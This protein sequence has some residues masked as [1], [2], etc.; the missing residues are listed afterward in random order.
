MNIQRFF[1]FFLVFLAGCSKPSEEIVVATAANVQYVMKEI[2]AEF[3]KETGKKIDIVVGSSGKLTTQIREGAP[4]DVFVSADTKYPQEIFKNG[5][6]A[7]KPRIYALGTLVL[8]SKKIPKAELNV[9]VLADGKIKK[10]AIP[11]PETAPYGEAAIQVLKSKNVFGEI[12]KKLVFGESIAQTAQYI[13]SG[14]VEA[15]FN[16]LSIVLSPEMKDQGNYIILDSTD[17]K[18]IEQAA[19]LLNH[20]EDSPKKKTSEQFYK[21]LYSQKA[22]EIFQKYG[23]K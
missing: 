5:G 14:N 8:W 20:S 11:N 3:E 22:K 13:T 17:Y 9:E 1:L 18:P 10:I 2:K 6:S 23:Y 21:F 19:I 7:E 15:G 12:E 4:F 16:A